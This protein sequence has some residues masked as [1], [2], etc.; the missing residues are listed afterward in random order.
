MS[1]QITDIIIQDCPIRDVL[2]HI[3]G[4]WSLLVIYVMHQNGSI[5]REKVNI[6]TL[7]IAQILSGYVEAR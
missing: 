7:H 4:K 1:D 5:A 6:K 3:C 2:S